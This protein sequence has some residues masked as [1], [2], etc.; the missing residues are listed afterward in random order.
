MRAGR[1]CLT[2]ACAV[3][4]VSVAGYLLAPTAWWLVIPTTLYGLAA[5]AATTA[6]YTAASGVI[7]ANAVGAGFGLLTSASLTGL[8]LSPVVNGLLGSASFRAVFIVDGVILAA[9]AFL[10]VRF[11]I[12]AR[13]PPAPTPAPE[14]L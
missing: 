4:A 3:G 8:A 9:L 10:V 14:E 5:G 7:P 2:A 12:M 13:L 11:M 6:A 1:S